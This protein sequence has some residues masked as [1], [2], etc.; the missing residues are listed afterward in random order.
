MKHGVQHRCFTSV[1]ERLLATTQTEQSQQRHSD[2]RHGGGFRNNRKKRYAVVRN[3]EVPRSRANVGRIQVKVEAIDRNAS[4]LNGA[5][6]Q[7]L[8]RHRSREHV[9]IPYSARLIAGIP[10]TAI[11]HAVIV[12]PRRVIDHQ[13]AR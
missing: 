12:Y 9:T 7:D 1:N 2:E 8:E 13:L 6:L 11:W 3:I 4:T 5:F 10:G